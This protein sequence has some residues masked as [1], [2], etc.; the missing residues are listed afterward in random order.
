LK[1]PVL[2]DGSWQLLECHPAWNGN[3]TSDCFIAFGWQSAGQSPLIVAVNY[4]P[5]QSQCHVRL[6]L[7]D[8]GGK[9]WRLHDQLTSADYDWIGDD[10]AA[11]GLFVDMA[12]W[13]ASIF[14]LIECPGNG[15]GD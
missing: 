14:S 8:L 4:A 15:T 5:N 2:R 11:R 10:L 6:P 12:P 1:Q 3:W 13:Q 9:K 7:A